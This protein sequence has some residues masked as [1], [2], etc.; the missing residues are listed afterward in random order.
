MA[1]AGNQLTANA[2]YNYQYDD[3]ENLTYK[4]LQETRVESW[5]W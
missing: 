3:N 1:N 2:N 4:I 5:Q